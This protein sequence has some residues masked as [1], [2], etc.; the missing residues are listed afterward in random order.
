MS[1]RFFS[2]AASG[3]Q[4]GCPEILRACRAVRLSEEKDVPCISAC[5]KISSSFTRQS[6]YVS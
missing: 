3:V 2:P 6:F 5:N 1:C 4:D